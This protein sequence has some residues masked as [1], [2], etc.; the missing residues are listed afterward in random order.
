M[1][2]FLQPTTVI[3]HF[4]WEC[5]LVH[6]VAFRAFV[7]DRQSFSFGVQLRAVAL[8]VEPVVAKQSLA[9]QQIVLISNV[10]SVVEHPV[11]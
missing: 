8:I 3:L 5:V 1:T 11:T 6:S 2:T 9:L 7:V 10:V 4:V